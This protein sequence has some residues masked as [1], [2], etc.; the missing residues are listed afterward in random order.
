MLEE[1]A[2]T[3]HRC[4]AQIENKKKKKKQRKKNTTAKHHQKNQTR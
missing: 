4:I 1:H 2:G 3:S